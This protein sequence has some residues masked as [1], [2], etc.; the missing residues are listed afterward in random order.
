MTKSTAFFCPKEL[1]GI[2]TIY[3]AGP[4]T[5]LPDWNREAFIHA[6]MFLTNL[7]KTVLSPVRMQPAFMPER[8]EHGQYMEICL[9]MIRAVDAVYFLVGWE[10]SKG[11]KIEHQWA[12]DLRKRIIYQENAE[13][14]F[15]RVLQMSPEDIQTRYRDGT[16]IWTLAELNACTPDRIREIVGIPADPK[17]PPIKAPRIPRQTNRDPS[18]Q[19][20]KKRDWRGEVLPLL[21]TV[22]DS[23]LAQRFCVSQTA[24]SIYR[25]E[26][27]IDACKTRKRMPKMRLGRTKT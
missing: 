1:V 20:N 23:E 21:G 25:K 7:G 12:K 2:G 15:S 18:P 16:T 11:A 8:I 26:L 22:S 4:M 6:D 14:R 3:V 13:R 27:G 9:A 10:Q 17:D 24:I 19:S 5:G